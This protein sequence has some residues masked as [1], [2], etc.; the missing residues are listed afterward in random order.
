MSV[1]TLMV[2]AALAASLV[3]VVQATARL[4]PVIALVASGIETL[5]A[6]KIVSFSVSGISVYLVLAAALLVSGGITWFQSESKPI[7]TAATVV[8][9]I[10]AIQVAWALKIG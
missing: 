7:V 1:A 3:L 8:T 10:G 9:L 2:L 4:F 5:L 6:F